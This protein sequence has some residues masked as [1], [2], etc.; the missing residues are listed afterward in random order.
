MKSD[1]DQLTMERPAMLKFLI[2]R[3]EIY[4]MTSVVQLD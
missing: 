2:T 1:G 4:K 3:D